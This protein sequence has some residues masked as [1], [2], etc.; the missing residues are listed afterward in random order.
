METVMPPGNCTKHERVKIGQSFRFQ[1]PTK[2][3]AAPF[4]AKIYVPSLKSNTLRT[5]FYGHF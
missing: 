4:I 3:L 5:N 1:L 2:M